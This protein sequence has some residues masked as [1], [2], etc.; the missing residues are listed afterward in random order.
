MNY[1]KYEINSLIAEVIGTFA[2]VFFGCG[3]IIVNNLFGGVIGHFGIAMAFGVIVMAM[4]YS[5]GNISGAHLNPAV[6]I[7]FVVAGRIKVKK[8]VPYIIAQLLG[9]FIASSVHKLAFPQHATLGATLPATSITPIFAFIVE[10]VLTF[11]LMFVIVN[12]SSGHKEKGIMAGVAIG[13]TV[14]LAALV[15]GPLC[16]A[17]MNPA[18]SL[19]PTIVSLNLQHLWLYIVG[20]IIGAVLAAPMCRVIQ[21]KECCHVNAVE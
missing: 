7:G 1:I 6:T 18:R 19:A 5:I 9:A 2:L 20:P 13:A 11:V 17:S 8:A 14:F 3:A 10:I 12:V 21:G 4:I 15:G 16:G